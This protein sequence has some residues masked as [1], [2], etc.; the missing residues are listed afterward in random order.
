MSRDLRRGE[1]VNTLKDK[2]FCDIEDIVKL[3]ALVKLVTTSMCKDKRPTLSMISPVRAKLKKNFEASHE[4]S[5]VIREMKQAFRNDLEKRYTSLDDLFN[6]A[7]ALDPRF[8]SRPFLTDHDAE[9]THTSITAEAT[10]LHNKALATG[11]PVQ[12]GPL[13]TNPCQT[14]PA[15]SDLDISIDV[16]NTQD[17]PEDDGTPVKKK[18]MSALDQLL[19][20]DFEVRMAATSVRDKASEEVKRYRERDPLPLEKTHYR[21]GKSSKTCHCCHLSLKDT[22]ASRPP[23]WHLNGCSVLPEIL[24]PQSAVYSNMSMWIS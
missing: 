11:D 10:S 15:L 1:E 17:E 8:K 12:R 21:G 2:D 7:A 20:K 23:V 13:Q 22:S 5:V 18:K 9:R 3:M 19:G 6:T 14:E 16:P 4:D 24:F